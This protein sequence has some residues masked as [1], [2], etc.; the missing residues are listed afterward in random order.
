MPVRG[1]LDRED[2]EGDLQR[3]IAERAV[4]TGEGVTVSSNHR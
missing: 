2:F 3:N 4:I 1:D